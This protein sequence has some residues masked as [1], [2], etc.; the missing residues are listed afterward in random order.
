MKSREKVVPLRVA[1]F[2]Y[3]MGLI[4]IIILIVAILGLILGYMKGFVGQL[5]TIC[6][7]VLGIIVCNMFGDWATSILVEIVPESAGWP[8]PEYTTSA[9]ANIVLFLIV[10]LS[11]KLVGMMF[12]S[13]LKTLHLNLFDRLAG[14]LFCAFKYLL[15]V[16]IVL[17]IAF[18]FF[19]SAASFANSGNALTRWTMNLTPT[20]L[21][22][23]SLPQMFDDLSDAMSNNNN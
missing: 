14:S 19:P 5:S 7:I 11:I 6:G 9:I 4:D 2:Y 12:K 8:M 23:N 10:F 20:L 1:I 21:G 3:K 16:S 18:V 15:V 22:A 13:V 17:N